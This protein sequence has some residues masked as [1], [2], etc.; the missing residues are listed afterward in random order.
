MFD[1]AAEELHP[2]RPCTATIVRQ[3]TTK[4]TG[5]L[6]VVE[7]KSPTSHIRMQ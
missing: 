1:E 5:F 2:P 4:T 7:Q 6:H 3:M